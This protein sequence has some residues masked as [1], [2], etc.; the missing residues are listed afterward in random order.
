MG[1]DEDAY[2]GTIIQYINQYLYNVTEVIPEDDDE[3]WAAFHE[4]PKEHFTAIKIRD[5]ARSIGKD[6]KKHFLTGDNEQ[7]NYA[8]TDYIQRNTL[9]TNEEKAS[10]EYSWNGKKSE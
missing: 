5:A 4:H 2:Y 3:V 8:V 7:T 9:L 6:F 1:S 10:K